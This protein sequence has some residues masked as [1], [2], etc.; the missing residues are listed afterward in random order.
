MKGAFLVKRLAAAD[1]ATFEKQLGLIR[2]RRQRRVTAVP[3]FGAVAAE[4]IAVFVD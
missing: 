1:I 4:W 3:L 2:R